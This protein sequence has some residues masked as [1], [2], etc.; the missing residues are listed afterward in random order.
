MSGKITLLLGGARSGKSR[1]GESL[2]AKTGLQKVYLATS[3]ARD[4]EMQ[5]RINIH[6]QD[7]ADHG[8]ITVE[9]PLDLAGCILQ[10][11]KADRVVF[12]DCLTLWLSN[13]ME[14]EQSL[15]TAFDDLVVALQQAKG[16]VILISNE[17]GQGIVPM[18][19]LARRFRDATGQLHQQVAA[20]ADDAALV[21]AG[22]P[23][24]LKK[25]GQPVH[26]FD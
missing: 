7:R 13:V 17:V 24:L 11:S 3:E 26:H 22:L 20:I 4:D 1:L 9:E 2:A 19:A 18:N 8:W 16:P 15:D 10:E 25:N 5:D 14:Q 6:Q 21:V 12:V 23:L